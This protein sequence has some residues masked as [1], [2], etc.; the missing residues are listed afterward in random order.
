MLLGIL[1]VLNVSNIVLGAV[2]GSK[3]EGFSWKK[4]REGILKIFLF[5]FSFLAFCFCIEV[6]PIVLGR[7]NIAIPTD[8]ISLVEILGITLTAYKKYVKDCYEKIYTILDIKTE[9]R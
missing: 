7:I 1:L 9:K 2:I 6:T 3:K 4:I 8:I 5:S